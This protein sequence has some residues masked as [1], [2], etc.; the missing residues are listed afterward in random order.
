MEPT[1]VDERFQERR[2][3][4]AGPQPVARVISRL[5]SSRGYDREQ[6]AGRLATAWAEVA[7]P[8]FRN[9]SRA[10]AVRRGVLEV[11][12]SHSALV[13]EMGFHKEEVLRRLGEAVPAEGIA[14]IKCRVGDVS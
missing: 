4:S 6:S 7:P 8:A 2:R 3:E 1:R 11:V 9:R 13:Q 10:G 14:D 5:L 12:V